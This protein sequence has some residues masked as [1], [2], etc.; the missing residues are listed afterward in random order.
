MVLPEDNSTPRLALS[1]L[2]PLFLVL[3]LFLF[4]PVAVY[5]GN[6][7]EFH[8]ALKS[9]LLQLLL[10][11]AVLLVILAVAG[12]A[13]R[14]GARMRLA[15]FIFATAVLVWIQG[16]LLVWRYGVFSGKDIEWGRYAVSGWVDSLIWIG[17]IALAVFFW[18]PV[19]KI[20]VFGSVV[21]I[22]L[23]IASGAYSGFRNPA[24]WKAYAGTSEGRTPPTGLFAFSS[25]QNVLQ[26]V[27][28][29]FESGFLAESIAS[30]GDKYAKALDGF[31]WFDQATAS[32][33][34][35]QMSVP[36]ILSGRIYEN[37][38]PTREFIRRVNRGS[39][40]G[41]LLW[42][43]GY[44]VDLIC[45]PVFSFK[46]SSSISYDV[47]VPYGVTQTQYDRVNGARM[48]DLALFRGAP[49]PL[50]R[51]IHNNQQ[52]FV[53][54]L[55]GR[56]IGKL[57]FSLF[58][59]K[60]FLDDMIRKMSLSGSKPVYKYLHL[61]TMHPP[62][63]VD[64]DCGFAPGLPL[65]RKNRIAQARCA[66]DQLAEFLAALK[67]AGVY[68][69]ALIV[70]Q[71]DHGSDAGIPLLHDD[72]NW[73]QKGLPEKPSVL[74]SLATPLLA[75]KPP[76][77]AG[78]LKTSEAP[79]ELADVPMT[80]SSLLN[81]PDTFP[82][83]NVFSV[84]PGESRERRFIYYN[85]MKTNWENEY[86]EALDEFIISGDP[87][88]WSSWRLA[89]ALK[90][91]EV[92]FETSRIDFGI[93]QSN[94]FKRAGWGT[95]DKDPAD[96]INMNWALGRSASI[97]VSLPADKPVVMTA[98]VKSHPFQ[99]AQVITVRV[100][101]RVVGKW[102]LDAPWIPA[103]YSVEIP[104]REGRPKVSLIEFEF[105]ERLEPSSANGARAVQFRT[106]TFR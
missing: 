9:I 21:F 38:V 55:V 72:G 43:H 79:V 102:I 97:G 45:S 30:D 24:A 94:R 11:A 85:W 56:K 34:S 96:G 6:V 106:I 81:L 84:E 29:G 76:R 53:R 44:E 22:S 23:Q 104:P 40:V 50:K 28:D 49:Q 39:T 31:T 20:A 46:A 37:E 98:L 16:N 10:P 62:I 83:R 93:R 78:P 68:D 67:K 105:S 48:L 15:A 27:L 2:P 64:R 69:S 19:S 89:R 14:P 82:G 47:D 1:L 54:R 73:I 103:E 12:F 33:P 77:A 3:N 91:P 26:I 59:H 8:V 95:N 7:E 75:V 4:L 74:A 51:I 80:I 92:S 42:D 35:T 18:K 87:R 36:A 66:L 99:K 63:L 60:A 58:S 90:P 57:E 101:R 13:L 100:D 86:F 65:S 5:Q 41:N 61:M 17:G 88:D 71:A 52:W 25:G 70:L 32:F